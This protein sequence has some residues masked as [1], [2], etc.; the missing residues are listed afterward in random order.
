MFKYTLQMSVLLGVCVGC[1]GVGP[2]SVETSEPIAESDG[3]IYAAGAVDLDWRVVNDTVMGGRSRSQW[4]TEPGAFG[5]FEGILSLE[6]NGG[7]ASVRS[8]EVAPFSAE[9][10]AI[11]VRVRGDGRTYRLSVRSDRVGWG[12][13]YQHVFETRADQ[14]TEVA[15]PLAEFTARWRGRLVDSA[16]TLRAL[17]VR[18]VGFLLADKAPGPFRLDVAQIRSMNRTDLPEDMP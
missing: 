9:D 8:S 15:L 6:N 17:D 18:S 1:V 4:R 12:V 3:V 16:P 10:D 14:W 5:I 11:L 13:N 7:F 2:V